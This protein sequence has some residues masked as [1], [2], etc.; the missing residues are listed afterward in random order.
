MTSTRRVLIQ[1]L[2]TTLA[3]S[4][5]FLCSGWTLAADPL[6]GTNLASVTDASPQRPFID[7]FKQSRPWITQCVADPDCGWSWDTGEA[8][9]LDLDA[10]GWVVSLPA[11]EEPGYSAVGT[12]IDVGADVPAGRYLMLYDGSGEIAYRLAAR[13]I[14]D[15][16][17][18]GRDL[19]EIDPTSGP[20]HI[21][22]L[23]TDPEGSGDY[24]RNLRLVREQDEVLASAGTFSPD[25]IA[26]TE[27]FQAL[28][29]TDWL[30]SGN[31]ELVSWADRPLPDDARYTG[32]GGVPLEQAV[33]LAN[34]ITA[35]PWLN[36]PHQAD[37]DYVLQM[38]ELVRDQL[39][40]TLPIYLE[41]STE[42]WQSGG[43]AYAW[44]E[45]QGQAAWPS[46]SASGFIKAIN[47]YGRRSAEIC[48]I[49][50][51][52]FGEQ[53]DRV[54]CV[55]ASQA[56]NVGVGAAALACSLWSQGPCRDHGLD[57]LAIA[58]RFG[59]YLGRPEHAATVEGWTAQADGGLEA[60]FNELVFGGSLP[61]SA[62][63]PVDG[64]LEQVRTRMEIHA[65]LACAEGM[66]LL[67]YGG[68]QDLAGIW[69]VQWNNAIVE[70]FTQANRDP[71][72][73]ML[74][75]VWLTYWTYL[76]G[77]LLMHGA[78][79]AAADRTGSW[80][81][82]ETVTQT[83]AP[84]YDA[85]LA[86]LGPD[87]LG[88]ARLGTNLTDV[89]DWSS[90]VP[91]VDLFKSSRS[92]VT[93]CS[94]YGDDP[95]PGCTGQWDTGEADL[96][97]LDDQGWVR[98]LPA[99][100][101]APTF[102]RATAY[103]AFYPG[104]P[105][106]RYHVLYD[107]TGSIE[108]GL[109]AGRIDAES[110]PGRE[111]IEI[112]HD[113]NQGM[114]LIIT[115]TDPNGTGDYLRNIRI[116][117]EAVVQAMDEGT[118][119]ALFNPDF[120]DRIRPFEVLRFMAWMRTNEI[121]ITDWSQRPQ[122]DDARWTTDGVPM[123]VMLALAAETGAD[124]WLNV[125]HALDDAGVD[126]MAAQVLAAVGTRQRVYFELSNE[127]WNQIMPQRD[128]ALA[129]ARATWPDADTDDFTLLL[130]WYG[131]RSAEICDIVKARFGADA[132]RVR[133]VIGGQSANNWVARQSLDC[134]LWAEGPCT[135]HGIDAV[136]IAPYFGWYLAASA[137]RDQVIGW[138]DQ[139]DGGLDTLFTELEQGGVL[140]NSP[141]VGV[142]DQVA[143]EIATHRA[144]ADARG[145]DLVAYEGGQHL[146]DT[147]GTLP[148]SAV[149]LF[150]AA[151]SDARMGELYDA[152]LAAWAE[153]GGGLF[154]NFNDIEYP[155]RY[156][157]WGVLESVE[158]TTSPR[159][160]A[161]LRYLA[162]TLCPT[163]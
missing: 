159:Y 24:L 18:P 149:D 57:A 163:F 31:A 153:Q 87:G 142:I 49:W 100:A 136:A 47:W 86:Y 119:P 23:S 69:G 112:N 3:L 95:D 106:G 89:N 122:V 84:K 126:A 111:L 79:I 46:V 109:G 146:A 117:P 53:A 4:G 101:D 82:L 158:Q 131:K 99:P 55:V 78:D 56:E 50:K 77:G 94:Y 85:L 137:V 59:D 68:G 34:R 72:M 74:Y 133:C 88:R 110:T 118:E 145:L 130:N 7:L 19:L 93:Q 140:G 134:P 61:G 26:R 96:L 11:P 29:F 115:A 22:L 162:G 155:G 104:F 33:A 90:Q 58:P 98:A 70:L 44:L 42:V 97:D 30:R 21:Q 143:D 152:Y 36:V 27:P 54:T 73:G 161:L 39:D 28:R 103:W 160:E 35:A 75:D 13:R 48:G 65:A 41:Y 148:D 105:G 64:A 127:V 154:V 1:R 80:G 147:F 121:S 12:L 120:I 156:G 81:A 5:T 123:E 14:D 144:L 51:Q 102:T 52:A 108:Y 157:A 20:I 132:D 16:S 15:A 141:G 91:F 17:E 37:D 25:F 150:T 76:H 60:L 9:R 129:A 6:L 71:R 45:Q 38:A 2:A 63:A 40:A 113:D 114:T 67:G 116:L 8:D 124:L 10:R 138:T 135:D 107:G 43:P 125:P 32:P 92:W 83:E 66:T 128:D 139:A 62:S 151:N